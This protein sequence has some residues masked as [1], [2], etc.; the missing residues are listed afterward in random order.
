MRRKGRI[1]EQ[2]ARLRPI[3]GDK[4]DPEMHD[5]LENAVGALFRGSGMTLSAAEPHRRGTFPP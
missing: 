1:D 4:R 2:F 3:L 5:T